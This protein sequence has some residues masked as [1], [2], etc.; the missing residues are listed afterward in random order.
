M[1]GCPSAPRFASPRASEARLGLDSRAALLASELE[2]FRRLD[3]VEIESA[4]RLG[5][6]SV[7]V[8]GLRA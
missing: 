4:S 8:V 6:P 7:T 3:R 5:R 2:D 1:K